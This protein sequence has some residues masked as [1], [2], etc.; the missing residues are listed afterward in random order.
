MIYIHDFGINVK[1]YSY[2][3][4][5]NTF[6]RVPCQ[7][8]KRYDKLKKNGFRWR[9]VVGPDTDGQS[10]WIPIRVLYC[11]LCCK[12]TSIL[13]SFCVPYKIH[14]LVTFEAF[15]L[16]LLFTRLPLSE[17]VKRARKLT[18]YYQ[19][20]QA[21]IKSF[22]TNIVNLTCQIRTLIPETPI[23]QSSLRYQQVCACWWLLQRLA[24]HLQPSIC[25][26]LE[27][28][29]LFLWQKTKLGLFAYLG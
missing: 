11:K 12:V 2:Q 20:A 16:Y 21:W 3:G 17:I 25:L 4:K 6:P 26:P 10:L 15:F 7:K 13:P 29:Q 5:N 8:C 1:D 27:K 14:T 23:N 19:L 18:G 22:K 9:Y 28:A 24:Q